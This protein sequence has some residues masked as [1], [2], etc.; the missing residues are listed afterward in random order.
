MSAVSEEP[1]FPLDDATAKMPG[2]ARQVF[3][4]RSQGLGEVVG[5][6]KGNDAEGDQYPDWTT[7]PVPPIVATPWV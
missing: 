6:P 2:N 7:N 4:H 3:L 5:A 1:L